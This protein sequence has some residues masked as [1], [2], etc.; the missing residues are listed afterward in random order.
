[1]DRTITQQLYGYTTRRTYTKAVKLWESQNWKQF[2][3]DKTNLG[4]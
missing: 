4:F 3:T 2:K 1:M